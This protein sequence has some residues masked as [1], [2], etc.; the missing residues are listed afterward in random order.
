VVGEAAALA[1]A[2]L[3]PELPIDILVID[4][5]GDDIDAY[6]ALM[7]GIRGSHPNMK[8]TVLTFERSPDY[9][10]KAIGWTV[11]SYLF[12]DMPAAALLSA[13]KIIKLGQQIFPTPFVLSPTPKVVPAP[14]PM[15]LPA[16]PRDL[17]PQEAEILRQIVRGLSN[18]QIA[19]E[20][21]ISEGTIKAHLKS[22]L[23]K[24]RVSNRTQ[25]AVWALNHGF[26]SVPL[27]TPGFANEP[28][29]R[30]QYAV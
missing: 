23:R 24:M 4:F 13:F 29:E 17:S 18:K 20:L 9:L 21:S 19:R 5:Q 12:K 3:P 11:D 22:L 7:K 16:L 15:E 10:M 30:T 2:T 28:T 27:P 26:S 25:A 6:D 8:L 14:A 1:G